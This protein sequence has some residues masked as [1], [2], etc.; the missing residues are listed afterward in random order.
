M[1][2]ESPV[3]DKIEGE[4]IGMNK[5][6]FTPEIDSSTESNQELEKGA[7]TAI[8]QSNG[9]GSYLYRVPSS[10][11]PSILIDLRSL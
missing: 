8:T 5:V 3:F 4:V 6:I 2:W 10:I 11:S 9:N 7:I 1:F